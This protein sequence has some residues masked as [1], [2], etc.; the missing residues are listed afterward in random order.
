M[1]ATAR[2]IDETIGTYR[3]A[4]A[5]NA[6]TAGRSGSAI[7]LPPHPDGEVVVTADLHGNRLNFERLRAIADLEGNP[8]THLV[9]QEVCHG[10]P[11]YPGTDGCMSHL[12]LE[13]VARLKVRHRDRF[14]FLLS[15]HEWAEILDFPIS[16]S[17]RLL[18]L[19]FRCGMQQC[20]GD[21][22]EEVREAM[23]GFLRSLPLLLR[24]NSTVVTHAAPANLGCVP[25]DKG[26]FERELGDEDLRPHGD[27]FRLLWGRDFS[28]ENGATFADLLNAKVLIHGHEPCPEGF[29]VPNR[30]QIILDCCGQP[31]SYLRIPTGRDLTHDEAARR[32]QLFESI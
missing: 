12:L 8:E 2:Q 16:K 26:V 9:M 23:V 18:N 29:C 10:G 3:A 22:T 25:F 17:N 28:E 15:N 1:T 24:I 20:Y 21:R 5:A 19:T 32:I 13:D 11:V 6:E 27:V 31:A 14:H 4:T 7:E 30:H